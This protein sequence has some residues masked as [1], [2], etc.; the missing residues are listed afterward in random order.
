MSLRSPLSKVKGLGSAKAGMHHW[1][2]QRVTALALIPLTIW[3]VV[4]VM[5][6]AAAGYEDAVVWVMR[7]V[8]TVLLLLFTVVTLH[9]AQLGLQVVIEDYVSCEWKKI[10]SVILVKFLAAL[11]AVIGV[12]S[13]MR[14]SLGG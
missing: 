2:L 14:I 10:S 12:V 3:F 9:H 6:I 11:L 7:P 4:S 5:C 8:N 1:W 13:I